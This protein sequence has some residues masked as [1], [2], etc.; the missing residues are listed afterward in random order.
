M[1][2][3]RG[4]GRSAYLPTVHRWK[5]R[6][7]RSEPAGSASTS[8]TERPVF[9]LTAYR[10]ADESRRDSVSWVCWNRARSCA[11]TGTPSAGGACCESVPV[12]RSAA[13]RAVRTDRR[14]RGRTCP[15]PAMPVHLGRRD[16]RPAGQRRCPG[17]HTG[18]DQCRLPPPSRSARRSA[19]KPWTHPSRAGRSTGAR[20]RA[21]IAGLRRRW[22]AGA[23]P[24]R[25]SGVVGTRPTASATA[26]GVGAKASIWH[27]SRSA[28]PVARS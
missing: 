1:R 21:T 19:E 9:W 2:I 23:S 11:G 28:D 15:R 13:H 25:S 17:R 20:R 12:V 10:S 3:P 5:E 8:A 22:G 14:R 18:G 4:E 6:S 26:A 24:R 16:R 27:S 7:S